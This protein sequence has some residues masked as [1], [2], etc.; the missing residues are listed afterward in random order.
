MLRT[1]IRK[2][3]LNRNKIKSKA[4]VDRSFTMPSSKNDHEVIAES[5]QSVA[6]QGLM[7]RKVVLYV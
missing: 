2:A 7:A 6:Q 4:S 3:L 1:S 5:A